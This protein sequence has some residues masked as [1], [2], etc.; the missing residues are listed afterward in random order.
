MYV[1]LRLIKYIPL[2]GAFMHAVTSELVRLST[3]NTHFKQDRQTSGE[4]SGKLNEKAA[5][6]VSDMYIHTYIHNYT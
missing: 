3:E 2:H 6:L 5:N 1:K 4:A